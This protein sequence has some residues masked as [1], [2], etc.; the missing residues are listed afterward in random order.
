[1][2]EGSDISHDVGVNGLRVVVCLPFV[3][4]IRLG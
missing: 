4:T 3:T 1:M 2:M